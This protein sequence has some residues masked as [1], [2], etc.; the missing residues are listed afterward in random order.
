M[1]LNFVGHLWTTYLKPFLKTKK[2]ELKVAKIAELPVEE[3][4]S[5][6]ISELPVEDIPSR[7]ISKHHKR[8]R[9][10]TFLIEEEGSPNLVRYHFKVDLAG[11]GIW[12]RNADE[13]MLAGRL[14][15]KIR[16]ESDITDRNPR[17]AYYITIIGDAIGDFSV[18]LRPKK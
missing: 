4:P 11:D 18:A 8:V 12:I 9:T 16:P 5:R 17:Q 10:L 3:I 1:R 14:R 15:A 6:S 2:P 13:S 7:P